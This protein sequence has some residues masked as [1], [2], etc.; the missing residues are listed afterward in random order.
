[1]V[2]LVEILIINI[3]IH[4]PAE[5]ATSQAATQSNA[6]VHFN[7]RS[8]GGSDVDLLEYLVKTYTFQST[9]PRRERHQ[10]FVIFSRSINTFQSTLP[11]RER[12]SKSNLKDYVRN[13]S[14]HAPA[15]GAT[16][17]DHILRLKLTISI[18]A[19][20]EG[21]T[22][23]AYGAGTYFDI[24]QSTLPRRERPYLRDVSEIIS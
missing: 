5:G 1:M 15:E 19:P 10:K 22:G 2:V 18:H 11:R 23:Q 14:I 12:R 16:L 17:P 4:A 20:A 8:R 6:S 3:S 21:A 24:F 13:I 7:P 9:L